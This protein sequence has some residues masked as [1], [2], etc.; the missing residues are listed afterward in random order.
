MVHLDHHVEGTC[1][2][3]TVIRV[4]AVGDFVGKLLISLTASRKSQESRGIERDA[5]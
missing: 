5:R 1:N 4:A 3:A 2:F